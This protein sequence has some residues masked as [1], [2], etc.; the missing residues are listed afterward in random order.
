[1]QTATRKICTQHTSGE[2]T[3][4]KTTAERLRPLLTRGGGTRASAPDSESLITMNSKYPMAEEVDNS[5]D[6][7]KDVK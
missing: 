1:M 6:G 3:T 7:D 4:H 2:P 5:E